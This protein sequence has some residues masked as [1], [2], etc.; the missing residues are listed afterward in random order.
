MNTKWFLFFAFLWFVGM[1]MGATYDKR[2]ID[3][4]SSGNVTLNGTDTAMTA[5]TTLEYLFDFS[6]NEKQTTAG[7]VFFKVTSKDYWFTWFSILTFNFNFLKEVDPAT[8]VMT[9][10][11]ISY[12]FKILGAIGV[13][14]AI[15]AFIDTLQGFI[16]SS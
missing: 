16:P 3:D 7:N 9:D 12:V 13:L 8:G 6:G 1:I 2:Y 14:M 4:Y 5:Q 10:T 15:I 11:L